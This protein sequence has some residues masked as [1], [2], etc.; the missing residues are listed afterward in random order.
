M[1][2]NQTIAKTILSQ[3]GGQGFIVMTGARNLIAHPDGLSFRLPGT[4]TRNRINHVRITLDPCDTYT[5]TFS[6]IRGNTVKEIAKHDDIYNDMLTE[7]FR[8]VTGLETR[9]PRVVFGQ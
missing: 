8:Y 4:L 7:L 6:V 2:A 5:V 3:L 9:M 1:S